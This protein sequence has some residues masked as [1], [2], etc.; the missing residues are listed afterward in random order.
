MGHYFSSLLGREG[1]SIFIDFENAT[2][3]VKEQKVWDTI[4]DINGNNASILAGIDNYKGQRANIK[5]AVDAY[6]HADVKEIEMATF[7]SLLPGVETIDDFCQHAEALKKA[8][9]FLVQEITKASDAYTD[10]KHADASV[11]DV[12]ALCK[13]LGDV[14]N[15]AITFDGK[16]IMNSNVPN[17]FSFYRRILPKHEDQFDSLRVGGDQLSSLAFFTCQT[18]PMLSA[19][20]DGLD[21]IADEDNKQHLHTLVVIANACMRMVKGGKMDGKQ[22]LIDFC[23]NTMTGCIVLYDYV[24]FEYSLYPGC[25]HKKSGIDMKNCIN[26]LKKHNCALLLNWL[27]YQCKSYKNASS[28]LQELFE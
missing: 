16:R 28:S 19:L 12:P 3:S 7:K 6:G 4:N 17:D 2:P 1:Q 9:P 18:T 10:A 22:S 8:F 23:L 24:T 11:S 21:T 25:Y 15:F 27:Q 14:L 20:K 26:I 5:K 13:Q